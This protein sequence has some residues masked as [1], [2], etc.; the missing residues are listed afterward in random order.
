MK[1]LMKR[2]N[3]SSISISH[4]LFHSHRTIIF[5]AQNS[6]RTQSIFIVSFTVLHVCNFGLK[7]IDGSYQS[8]HTLSTQNTERLIVSR[9]I[10]VAVEIFL[11]V[12]DAVHQLAVVTEHPALVSLV[13]QAVSALR[14]IFSGKQH[15]FHT[16]A[17][18]HQCVA[19]PIRS[20]KTI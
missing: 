19:T 3:S 7:N 17:K 11:G 4:F 20:G 16:S 2:R 15:V 13:E 9:S 1:W 18:H 14:L 10:P 8:D 12:R 5:Q 6:A